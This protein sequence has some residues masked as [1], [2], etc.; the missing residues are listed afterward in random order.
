MTAG[1]QNDRKTRWQ[2]NTTTGKQNDRKARWQD[3]TMSGKHDDRK[4]KWQKNTM[5]GKHNDASHQPFLQRFPPDA[6]QN[7]HRP[8]Y[9]LRDT[10]A[11][12]SFLCKVPRWKCLFITC[13]LQGPRCLAKWWPQNVCTTFPR[14]PSRV[15]LTKAGCQLS[16]SGSLLHPL[17]HPFLPSHLMN[18]S[19]YRLMA[20]FRVTLQIR[21]DT[22]FWRALN[23]FLGE[24]RKK[25]NIFEFIMMQ[26]SPVSVFFFPFLKTDKIS[27]LHFTS[28]VTGKGRVRY[29][30]C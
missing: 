5:T 11:E 30:G 7:A 26:F 21:T 16:R 12:K 14:Q 4:A 15:A 28:Y 25:A 6:Y 24:E 17:L 23:T 9:P 2:E 1:K 18:I 27:R 22:Y 13:G 20:W 3:N 19:H 10:Q 29:S 8:N